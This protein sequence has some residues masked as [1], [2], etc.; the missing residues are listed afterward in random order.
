MTRALYAVAWWAVTAGY[1]VR[2]LADW[3]WGW[4]C[5]KVQSMGV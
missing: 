2:D 3:L 1:L 4:G 5:M